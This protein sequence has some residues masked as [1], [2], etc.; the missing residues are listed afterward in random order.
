MAAIGWQRGDLYEAYWLC[1]LARVPAGYWQIGNLV[2]CRRL[3]ARWGV[4]QFLKG[5]LQ[6]LVVAL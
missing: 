1:A 5:V 2:G 3:T 6:G 4:L